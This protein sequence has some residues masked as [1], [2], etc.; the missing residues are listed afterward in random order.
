MN[1]IERL[2]STHVYQ[3]NPSLWLHA[4]HINCKCMYMYVSIQPLCEVL[5]CATEIVLLYIQLKRLVQYYT[6]A[7]PMLEALKKGRKWQPNLSHITTQTIMRYT[8]IETELKFTRFSSM[9]Q[10]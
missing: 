10:L 4:K 2:W 5:K 6:N 1:I 9:H 8:Y 7:M 3:Q